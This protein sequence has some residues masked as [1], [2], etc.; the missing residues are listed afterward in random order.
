[1]QDLFRQFQQQYGGLPAQIPLP[2]QGSGSSL[3]F[4]GQA[5][6]KPQTIKYCRF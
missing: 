5:H 6:S 3:Y 4:S 1:M 2:V